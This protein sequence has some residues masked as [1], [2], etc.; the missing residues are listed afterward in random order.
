M[1]TSTI[2]SE[3]S[4]AERDQYRLP[5][6]EMGLLTAILRNPASIRDVPQLRPEHFFSE[7]NQEIFRAMLAIVA[8]AGNSN[9]PIDCAHL[10]AV[11]DELGMK[12]DRQRLDTLRDVAGSDYAAQPPVVLA[13]MIRENAARRWIYDACRHWQVTA[14]RPMDQHLAE[15]RVAIESLAAR[16]ASHDNQSIAEGAEN[17]LYNLEM[18][19]RYHSPRFPQFYAGLGGL[20]PGTLTILKGR[21]KGGKSRILAS[22][23]LGFAEA[24]IP[25]L[26]LDSEMSA[27]QH[28]KRLLAVLGEIDQDQVHDP[29]NA[30]KMAKALAHL[31][32][33]DHCIRYERLSNH[34][35]AMAAIRQFAAETR[36]H[37]IVVY[38]WL[39]CDM[40]IASRGESEYS[41]L[42][43]MTQELKRAATEFGIPI[44]AGNQENRGA[45]SASHHQRVQ[46]GEQFQAGSDRITQFCDATCSVRDIGP[47]VL[48]AMA[49]EFP[50]SR[51][52]HMLII[53]VSRAARGRVVVPLTQRGMNIVEVS[54]PGLARW[55]MNPPLTKQ[56]KQ[57][58]IPKLS[59]TPTLPKG[60]NHEPCPY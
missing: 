19:K 38:D 18:A 2:N 47:D 10:H 15:M 56:Q 54:D 14:D 21:S 22:S 41:V 49:K 35:T 55:L 37:G 42:G 9:P 45:I 58:A 29:T 1:I 44:I 5:S 43:R 12:I 52:S 57:L 31:R 59:S 20:A 33:I 23:V 26:W 11:S 50:E 16:L 3:L 51:A 30:E 4:E 6:A 17:A 39:T 40:S 25:V 13:G 27:E 46:S 28:G 34:P 24:G 8:R 53:D 48:A 36:G 32:S 7:S 60:E